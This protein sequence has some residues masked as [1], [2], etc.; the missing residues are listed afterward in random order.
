MCEQLAQGRYLVGE[1]LG[2]ERKSDA[3]TI[4]PPS[5]IH[6]ALCIVHTSNLYIV[7]NTLMPHTHVVEHCFGL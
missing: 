4:T 5:H 1:R 2:I 6:R 7:V 3:V